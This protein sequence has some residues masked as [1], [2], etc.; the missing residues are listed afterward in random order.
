MAP[1][2]EAYNELFSRV[3]RPNRYLA[4]RTQHEKL[5]LLY[6]LQLRYIVVSS[7]FRS[8]EKKATYRQRVDALPAL[9]VMSDSDAPTNFTREIHVLQPADVYILRTMARDVLS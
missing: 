9:Y 5:E 2:T 4:F 3:F 8:D 1:R 7:Q 6:V